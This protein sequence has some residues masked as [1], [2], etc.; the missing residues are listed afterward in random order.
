MLPAE[1]LVDVVSFLGYYDL[2]SLKLANKPFSAIAN[3]CADAICL[4]DFS[5]LSFYIYGSWIDVFRLESDGSVE[6]WVCELDLFDEQN[7]VTFVT[8]AFRNCV[9]GQ[10]RISHRQNAFDAAANTI[11]VVDTLAVAYDRF[12]SVQDLIDCVDS[13]RRVEV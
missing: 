10:L 7:L 9:V 1:A 4:F 5:N 3:Q 11:L 8:D 13:F 2:G 12:D 6:T